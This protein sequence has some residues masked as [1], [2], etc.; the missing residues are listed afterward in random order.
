MFIG[1]F[2]LALGTKRS[3]SRTSLGVLFAAAQWPD[4]LWPVLLLAGQE[5]VRVAPGDTAFTPLAF[6][7]YPISHSLL[8]VA[9]W[10]L[11]LGTAY[12]LVRRDRSG[13]LVVALLVI[14]HWVL[15]AVTHRPDLPVVPW[16][17]TR[18]GLGLWNSVPATI[19]VETL[20]YVVGV[21]LYLR[22]T[23]SRDRVGRYGLWTLVGFLAL[24]YAAN[25][26]GDAP[27]SWEAVAYLTLA[28]WLLPLWAAWVDRHRSLRS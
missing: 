27:P 28:I 25:V 12:L 21:A 16:G 13:A 4:L 15:D 5:Q 7:H 1:H 14:S 22:T 8:A 3:A 20:M 9:G 6:V 2:A 11:L 24:V 23:R 17:E 10:A 19:I 26:T 18:V